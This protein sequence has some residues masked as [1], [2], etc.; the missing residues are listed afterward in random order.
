MA[1]EERGV[2]ELC[3]TP[4]RMAEFRARYGVPEDVILTLRPEDDLTDGPVDSIMMPVTAISEAGIRFPLNPFLREVM[5]ELGA[6]TN[7]TTINTLRI[8]TAI[9]I[10]KETEI[11]EFSIF[12]LFGVYS[13][14]WNVTHERWYLQRLP[15]EKHDLI[16][17]LPDTNKRSYVYF[18]VTGNYE[19][20]A[21]AVDRRM[22]LP[23]RGRRPGKPSVQ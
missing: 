15:N 14:N 20:P 1:N 5:H 8:L 4:E 6:S 7:N 12:D 3:N 17:D 11:P 16:L 21:E 22:P 9:G 19:F 13:V 2:R 10:L 18:Y 23:R